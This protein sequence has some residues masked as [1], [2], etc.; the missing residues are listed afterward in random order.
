MERERSREIKREH[1][2]KDKEVNRKRQSLSESPRV[3]GV[4][5][6]GRK[7]INPSRAYERT[8]A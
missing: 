2:N 3:S 8:N 5:R 6:E 7:R 1:T 4:S